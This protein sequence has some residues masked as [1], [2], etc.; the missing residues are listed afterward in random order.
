MHISKAARSPDRDKSSTKHCTSVNNLQRS[1]VDFGL[2]FERDLD[3]A[4]IVDADQRIHHVNAAFLRLFGYTREE[5]IGRN[6]DDLIVPSELRAEAIDIV[7]RSKQGCELSLET[8]RR[9]KDGRDV[10]VWIVATTCETRDGQRVCYVQ[11]R[12]ISERVRA[13]E[14]LARKRSELRTIVEHAPIGI[15]L[16]DLSGVVIEANAAL[17]SMLAEPRGSLPG[18]DMMHLMHPDEV[19][20]LRS[21]RDEL[22]RTNATVRVTTRMLRSDASHL[23]ARATGCVIRSTLGEPRHIIC[24]IEDVT[25]SRLAAER[26]KAEAVGKLAGGIAHDFN[27]I[28][29]ALQGHAML[30]LEEADLNEQGRADVQE[31]IRSAN[32]AAFLTRQLLAYSRQQAL[33]PTVVGINDVLR[34]METT[35]ERLAGEDIRL[36][37]KFDPA[38]PC[39]RVD[40]LQLEQVILNL[41][42][43]ARDAMPRGGSLRIST[44]CLTV[45]EAMAG[46]VIEAAA[47]DYVEMAVRD[48]GTG[49]DAE[50]VS[51]VFDPFFTTREPGRGVGL[52]LSMVYGIVKQS[53]GCIMVES[54]IGRSTTFRVLLPRNRPGE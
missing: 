31:I 40:P 14:E 46:R 33:R 2:L 16:V 42:A 8:V 15:A 9:T 35:L 13:I 12:D 38:A 22:L 44:S 20:K 32:R 51:R 28:L 43:N 53:G 1:S 36:E 7:N 3:A 24:V 6:I 34:S 21:L 18:R 37:L 52:G 29:T 25:D 39:V 11:Y 30:L 23:W 49:M 4:V 17:E 27:N 48:E 19:D 50:T 54:E 41:V 10:D 26:N 47:G 5:L 45:T